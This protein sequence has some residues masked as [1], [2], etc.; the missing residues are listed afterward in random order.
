MRIL[1]A[2]L[3]CLLILLA[4]AAAEDEKEVE[5][6]KEPPK[7][8]TAHP[9]AIAVLR[10][11]DAVLKAVEATDSAALKALAEKDEPDPWIVADELCYRGE[12][13]AAEAFAKAA[14]RVDT[15][16]LPAYVEAWRKREPDEAD[17]QLLGAMIAAVGAREPQQ[18]I[19]TT[20]A[21]SHK[22]D[23]VTR[24]RLRHVRGVALYALRRLKESEDVLRSGA[25]AARAL[26]WLRRTSRMDDRAGRSANE[27]AAW[28]RA[29]AFWNEKLA[30]D[31]RRGDKSGA[32]NTL[33][34]IGTVHL[35]LGDYAK[36]LSLL[37]RALAQ[38]QALG[39]K[40]GAARTLG[41]VGNVHCSLADYPT[42][43]AIYERALAQL[44]ALGDRVGAARSLGNIGYVHWSLGDYAKALVAYERALERMNALGD[45]IG[46]A[47]TLG[48]IGSV[49]G[50]LGEHA[51]ALAL[52][53]RAVEQFNALGDKAGVATTLGD[54]GN[55]Y[56]DLGE[57]AKARHAYERSARAARGLRG[58]PLLA[59]ALRGL[60]RLHLGADKPSR[61][62]AAAHR[63]L[64]ETESLLGGLG[65][66]QGATA[67]SQYA[68]CTRS[69][70]SQL[71]ARATPPRRSRFS[72][73]AGRARCSTPWTSA[74]PCVG[75]P[76]RCPPN[77]AA[78][79]ARS[80]HG[81]GR[82]GRPTT[83][84][85]P[86]GATRRSARRPGPST[87]PARPCAT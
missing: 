65:E 70:R 44:E 15:E 32:A 21:F 40:A 56:G 66:E 64:S 34:D 46:A 54:I 80:R 4:P 6:K 47:T 22:L 31:E 14:P 73:V 19:E 35:S 79:I 27:R 67:R 59:A 77:C 84:R 83:R 16:A 63:A 17:R 58:T 76:S 30:L 60:A 26:G 10:A 78:W 49:Y 2:V 57:Y 82:P 7:P 45:K 72:R 11:A 18:V 24:I 86:R 20:A 50:A 61:A 85:S 23:T 55:V 8:R 69:V 62:L 75:R 25:K 52:L 1:I 51:K 13:D 42:A 29:L 74:R 48:N 5:P 12:H 38:Q 71:C 37:Q 68:P 9:A 53:Q 87:K 28:E 36:A 43:L 3:V 81:S 41:S 33:A 39:D